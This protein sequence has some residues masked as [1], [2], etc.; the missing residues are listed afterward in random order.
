MGPGGDLAITRLSGRCC[1]RGDRLGEGRP[2][3][4][5]GAVRRTRVGY[6]RC[7]RRGGVIWGSPSSARWRLHPVRHGMAVCAPP[8]YSGLHQR[9]CQSVGTLPRLVGKNA[10]RVSAGQLADAATHA[11]LSLTVLRRALMASREVPIQPRC[12]T[13]SSARK[14]P[15]RSRKLMEGFVVNASDADTSHRD[16][17]P[18]SVALCGSGCPRPADERRQRF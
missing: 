2:R 11:A 1:R 17:T 7:R 12:S 14:S 15:I 13:R 6:A 3:V 10:G 16:L 4:E 8:S 5:S 9:V 18:P